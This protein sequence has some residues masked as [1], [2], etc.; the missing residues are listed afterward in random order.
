MCVQFHYIRIST[1]KEEKPK[2]KP[3]K[4]TSIATATRVD[5]YLYIDR[6][7]YIGGRKSQTNVYINQRFQWLKTEKE[8]AKDKE[9]SES[10]VTTTTTM[11]VVATLPATNGVNV[12]LRQRHDDKMIFACY[13][14][15]Y[16]EYFVQ[17]H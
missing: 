1:L 17:F 8:I 10:A 3:T 5:V 9:K 2:E 13:E 16:G 12:P 14:T 7:I 4:V 15:E 6:Y 11:T